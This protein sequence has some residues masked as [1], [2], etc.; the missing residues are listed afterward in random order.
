[1][2][3]RISTWSSKYGEWKPEAGIARTG[4]PKRSSGPS[5]GNSTSVAQSG[6]E[7]QVRRFRAGQ[8]Q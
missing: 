3:A 8:A 2:M 7:H 4:T 6:L 1:M 5:T